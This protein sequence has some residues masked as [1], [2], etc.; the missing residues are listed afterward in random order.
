MP[1]VRT[2]ELDGGNVDEDA[3][4]VLVT[5]FGVSRLWNLHHRS[6]ILTF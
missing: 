1:V 3:Y 2:A 5:G 4:R 6:S